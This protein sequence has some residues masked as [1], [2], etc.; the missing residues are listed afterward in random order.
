[1]GTRLRPLIGVTGPNKGG[2]PA[3]LFTWLALWR[4]GARARRVTSAHP[5]NPAELDGLVIGGGAD[6]TEP[7]PTGTIT[8]PPPSK[9]VRWPRRIF[10][11]L[12]ARH[13]V[14]PGSAPL[15]A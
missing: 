2:G 8:T 11:L 6:V 10:D 3:W 14:L 7:L 5:V 1:M 15:G 12:F 9:H 13:W 4:A